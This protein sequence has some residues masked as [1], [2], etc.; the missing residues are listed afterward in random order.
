[1]DQSIGVRVLSPELMRLTKNCYVFFTLPWHDDWLMSWDVEGKHPSKWLKYES[2]WRWKIHHLPSLKDLRKPKMEELSPRS[3]VI[4]QGA[5]RFGHCPIGVL[6][7]TPKSFYNFR[8]FSR[9]KD[10]KWRGH[11]YV[12]PNNAKSWAAISRR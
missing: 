7:H 9:F 2:N 11:L 6:V 5:W 12:A 8:P 3:H 1:M 4:L 10:G